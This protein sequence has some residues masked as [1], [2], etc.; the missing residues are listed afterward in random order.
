MPNKTT[1]RNIMTKGVFTVEF[2]DPVRKADEIMKVENVRHVPVVEGAK[3]IG[4]ITERSLMEY[5]LRNLYDKD[6]DLNDPS[7]N[8]ISDFEELLTKVPKVIFPEDSVRKAV[9][10]MTKH[11]MDCLPVV[12]WDHNLQGI[13]TSYDIMLFLHKK[14]IEEAGMS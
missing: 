8:L 14:L 12:D 13:V 5:S 9:E 10:L 7:G 11:K 4:M 1:I 6:A 3:F 2:D